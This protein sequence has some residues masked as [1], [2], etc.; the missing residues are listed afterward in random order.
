[1]RKL[2][3]PG[4]P[5]AKGRFRIGSIT[6]TFVAATVLQLVG[7]GKLGLDD[8]ADKYLPEFAL[9]KRITVRMLL[10]HTSG[11]FNYTGEEKPDGTIEPGIPISGKEWLD[12]RFHN[13]HPEELVRLA[14]SKPANFQPGAKYS[15]S[16]TNYVLAGLLVEKVTGTPYGVQVARR[17]IKPLGL[18]STVVPGTNRAIP[19]PHA[20]NYL[21]CR[22]GPALTTVDVT[23]LDPSQAFSA[24]EMVST[25]QDLD[26]FLSSLLG[27]KLLKPGLLAE[28]LK[29]VPASN[30]TGYGLG[31]SVTEYAPGCIGIGHG[32]DIQ[33]TSADMISTADGRRHVEFSVNAGILEPGS[34]TEERTAAAES[35]L[36]VHALCGSRAE[37]GHR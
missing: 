10:Q 25:T 4:S 3:E 17:I 24:G 28:M 8:P 16:N 9:G 35:K 33:G 37:G 15:Y 27:G 31:I 20:H 12:K 34:K 1:M 14:L 23:E 7:E 11:L 32:G 22:Q 29:T 30:R 5:S 21:T 13:Y 26:T 36:V 19:G 18:D 2:G 6:K